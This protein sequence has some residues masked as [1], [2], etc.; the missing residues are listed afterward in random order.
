MIRL[1]R[2]RPS[3]SMLVALL[4]LVMA[5]T[6]SAVA[7]SLITSQQIKN[8][9][10]QTADISKKA[11]KTLKGKRG[12]TGAQGAQGPQGLK[13]DTGPKGDTGASG[14]KGDTGQIGPAGPFL[15][16]LPNGKSI[17]GVFGFANDGT[18]SGQ[19]AEGSISFGFPFATMPTVI[20]VPAGGPTPAGCSGTAASPGADSGKVCLFETFISQGTLTIIDSS[21]AD[22]RYGVSMYINAPGTGR[23]EV[24]GN[25]VATG[26]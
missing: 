25:W 26:N 5:T 15:D 16:A 7:A 22:H 10:I 6:G 21:Y 24:Y 11:Q 23:T 18:V 12:A 3:G 17:R 19:I 9:T 4:A 1:R 20:V 2:Y 14:P 8:G 13:G